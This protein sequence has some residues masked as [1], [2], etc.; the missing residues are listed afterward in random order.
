MMS[1]DGVMQMGRLV[2]RPPP[3]KTVQ[4]TF[5]APGY[6]D[7]TTKLDEK[8]PG[9]VPVVLAVVP[10]AMPSAAP[11]W[12]WKQAGPQLPAKTTA[13]GALPAN[14]YDPKP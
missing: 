3:G 1:V 7:D 14:P 8:T 5:S 11:T 12:N 10:S 6:V 13:T 4:V 9:P 2:P